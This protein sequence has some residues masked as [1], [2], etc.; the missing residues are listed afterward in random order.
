LPEGVDMLLPKG[1]RVVFQLHYHNTQ[2]AAQ[3]P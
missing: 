2:L 1:A 3:I